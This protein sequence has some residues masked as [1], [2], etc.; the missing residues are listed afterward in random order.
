M[1]CYSPNLA[2][3]HKTTK[4]KLRFSGRK[5][6]RLEDGT[7][8]YKSSAYLSMADKENWQPISLPCGQCIHCRLQNSREKAV[9]SMHEASLHENNC[10]LTLT[11][12]PE[13]LP[14]GGSI[15][16]KD[17]QKFMKRLRSRFPHIKI[18]ST[19]CAEYGEKLSRPHY[20]IL[21]FNFD[22]P[23]KKF[24]RYSEND[25]SQV[26]W[27]VFRSAILEELWTY[28]YS[29]IGTVTY[30]SAAYV[31]RY[32]TKKI[33]GDKKHGH[34]DGKLPERPVAV[35]NREGIGLPWLKTYYKE[36]L[37]T[38]SVSFKG[39]RIKMPRYYQKKLEDMFPSKMEQIK[40]NRI[41]KI[42]EIDLDSTKRRLKDREIV[43]GVKA[44]RLKRSYET[45]D[46]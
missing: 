24:W 40:K 4:Q 27:P 29:E 18:R 3:K 41:A 2:F 17:V 19:G 16:P 14:I 38:D 42:N 46:T 43:H 5:A 1:P 15:Q 10:F 36:V 11:Y 26:K 21:L 39:E 31:A 32:L 20:H 12:A 37:N 13:H 22:F 30:N 33:T 9:R 28:G 35:S 45:N 7:D 23:D 44:S 25:W 8:P 34:Y 6:F